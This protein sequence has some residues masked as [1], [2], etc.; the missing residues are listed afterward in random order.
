MSFRD[1]RI[2]LKAHGLWTKKRFGQNFLVDPS[3]PEQIARSGGVST[4]SRVVEIGAGCGTLTQALAGVGAPIIALEYD[5]ELI[6]VA[7]AE[8][9]HAPHVEVRE[10]NVLHVDW[11]G[12][13]DELG[14]KAF[15]PTPR[16]CQEARGECRGESMLRFASGAHDEEARLA[17]H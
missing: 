14:P 6:P 16:E 5:R 11:Q 8:L 4:Q 3:I 2:L 9:A 7:R 1:P 17:H 15:V 13:A 12:L 10:A